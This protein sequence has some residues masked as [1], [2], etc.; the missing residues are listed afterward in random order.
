[1]SL[2]LKPD[3]WRSADWLPLPGAS[4]GEAASPLG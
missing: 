4:A 2:V 1:V 3:S